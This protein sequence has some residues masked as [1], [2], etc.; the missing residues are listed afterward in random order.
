MGAGLF[1]SFS[2]QNPGLCCIA[3]Q[4]HTVQGWRGRAQPRNILGKKASFKEYVEITVQM[5]RKIKSRRSTIQNW[6][7]TSERSVAYALEVS[8]KKL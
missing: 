4:A 7:E 1:S 6:M 3:N 2:R 5:Q 8:E